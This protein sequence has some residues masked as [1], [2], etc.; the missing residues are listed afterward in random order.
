MSVA[1]ATVA[2]WT[3][4]VW[5][6]WLTWN[7]WSSGDWANVA[8]P[9]AALTFDAAIA[10]AAGHAPLVGWAA[11]FWLAA[12]GAGGPAARWVG[13]TPRGSLRAALGACVLG[14]SGLGA[15]LAG[16][17]FPSVAQALVLVGAAAGARRLRLPVGLRA[18]SA[19]EALLGLLLGVGCLLPLIGALAPEAS[20]DGMAYHLAHPE[21]YAAAHRVHAM[22]SHFL[23]TYPA[24]LEMQYLVARLVSGT[25]QLARLVHWGWGVLTLAALLGWARERMEG[26]W[27]LAAAVVFVF[28]PYVQ[29]VMMWAYVDLGAACLLTL[30]L[31]GALSARPRGAP[32]GLLC[33]LAAGVKVTGI[34]AAVLVAAI[35]AARRAPAGVWGRAAGAG[36]LA[37][38]PWAA[39]NF[40]FAGSP[41]APFFS[42]LLPVL[43][44]APENHA[45]YQQELASYDAGPASL[46]GPLAFFSR[47]W[48]A[49]VHNTGVLDTRAGMGAWFLWGLPLAAMA[50]PG[51]GP[52]LAA[53]GWYALW[54]L[55][56]HQV[57]YLLPA[58]PAAAIACAA[59]AQRVARGSRA[60]RCVV[61]GVG[62]L[63][64]WQVPLALRL[65]REAGDPVRVVFGAESP[66]RYLARGMPGHEP[67][68]R[69]RAWLAV[70]PGTERALVANQYGLGLFWGPRA[71]TQSFFDTPLIERVAAEARTGDDFRRR[72]RQ[73]RIGRVV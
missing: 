4:L 44:W 51:G 40:L 55:I 63:L 22:P 60:G 7:G 41:T 15:G 8:A 27:A 29:L 2:I 62:A 53:L 5:S 38:G 52:L 57:R 33:G 31:R 10:A 50:G 71:V 6:N 28:L 72:F 37:L 16:I 45:R 35:L 21:L 25:A 47:P 69:T 58:W 61:W 30:A 36:A 73:L 20:F 17:A 67:G 1:S 68:L 34:F 18:P 13:A 26:V 3:A 32:L 65:Q 14:F 54:Q 66:E 12:W 9:Y 24:L 39:K 46:H 42:G 23:A 19:A 64:V 11:V 56:P 59:V 43:W 48:D 70:Q 49:S